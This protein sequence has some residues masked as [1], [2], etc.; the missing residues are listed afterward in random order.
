MRP[1]T[2]RGINVIKPDN[3]L[4]YSQQKERMLYG[5]SYLPSLVT[6]LLNFRHLFTAD[7]L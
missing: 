1:F 3:S 5:S 4:C 6:L 2:Q 7:V